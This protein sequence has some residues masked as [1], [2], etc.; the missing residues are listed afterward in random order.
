MYETENNRLA[1]AWLDLHK[2]KNGAADVLRKLI[3]ELPEGNVVRA[4][5]Q[6][7]LDAIDDGQS[8]PRRLEFVGSKTQQ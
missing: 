4:T 8:L 7:L 6:S 1:L 5:G 2:K 3:L